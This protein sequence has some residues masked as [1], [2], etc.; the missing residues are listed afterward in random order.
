MLAREPMRNRLEAGS[1][2]R[3]LIRHLTAEAPE[4]SPLVL[5]MHRQVANGF[6]LYANYKHYQWQTY[7]PL[8][9]DL[10][11]LFQE[12]ATAVRDGLDDFAERA[13][14]LGQDPPAHLTE[15]LALATVSPAVS[16]PTLRD[17]IEEADRNAL[18]V[19]KEMRDAARAAT[20]NGDPGS[21]ELFSRV[22]QVHEKH[23]WW[24]RDI[25]KKRDG[26]SA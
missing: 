14:L 6:V 22:V 25:L 15:M 2:A 24:L 7:G 10:H 4:P 1:H 13:R 9:R 21:A 26:L 19:I 3:V 16:H 18:V 12:L 17:M 23:E 8:Y 11:V 5:A 20:D